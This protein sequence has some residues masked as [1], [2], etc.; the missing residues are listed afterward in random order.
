MPSSRQIDELLSKEILK[1][2]PVTFLIP[3]STVLTQSKAKH[4]VLIIVI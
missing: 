3:I 2:F 4:T 1:E